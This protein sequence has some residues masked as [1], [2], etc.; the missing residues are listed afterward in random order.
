[1]LHRKSE[2]GAM[3]TAKTQFVLRRYALF[4]VVRAVVTVLVLNGLTAV[5]VRV[6]GFDFLRVLFGTLIIGCTLSVFGVLL[7][8]SRLVFM[9][10][11]LRKQDWD[12]ASAC[13][14]T[15]FAGPVPI[16]QV[17]VSRVVEDG[18]QYVDFAGPV[19][20]AR[21]LPIDM[22]PSN[23]LVVK[24]RRFRVYSAFDGGSPT[25]AVPVRWP[26]RRLFSRIVRQS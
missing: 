23:V 8:Y 9:R 22:V 25:L 11:V 2:S 12:M 7:S 6:E 18:P 24:W 14:Q 20:F 15:I 26:L 19:R 4:L 17:M 16:A 13:S 21:Q 5:M 10:W 3:A 1:M